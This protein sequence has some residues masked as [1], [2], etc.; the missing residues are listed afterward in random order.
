MRV[1]LIS[2]A[3]LVGTLVLITGLNMFGM[4]SWSFFGK[5]GEQIR[6][7]IHKESQTYRDGMQ[8]NLDALMTDFHTSEGAARIGVT[9]AIRHQYSQTDVSRLPSY[10][11]DFLREIG[12][13]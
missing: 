12:I 6:Y 13:Y 3:G 7:D 8:R 5:W 1:I 11:Q 9:Q 2:L 4:V 10:Q